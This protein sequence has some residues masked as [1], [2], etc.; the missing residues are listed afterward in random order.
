MSKVSSLENISLAISIVNWR[1]GS[2]VCNCLESLNA[3]IDETIHVIVVDNGSGDGSEKTIA[4]KIE[5]EGW[6]WVTQIALTENRGFAAGNNAAIR[7]A[8]ANFP[9]LESLMLLNPDTIMLPGAIATMSD[10]L[11]S[12]SDVG[13]VG[14]RSEHLDGT[15]QDCSFKFYNPIS[16]FGSNLRFALLNKLLSR[17]LNNGEI[18]EKSIEVDWVSGAFMLIRKEVIDD[19][20]LM[21]EA[22]FLYFEEVDF[23]LR[24]KREGWRCWH[25]PDARIVHLVGQSSGVTSDR[26]GNAR[27]PVYWYESRSR[28]FL[29]NYGR[30]YALFCDLLAIIGCGLWQ[31]R[32]FISGKAN[33]NPV[34]Y[35]PDLVRFGTFGVL[36]S[37]SKP[38]VIS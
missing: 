35:L 22:Y 30:S 10:F 32:C 6:A 18:P 12:N 9:K 34:R 4:E 1:T 5:L 26:Q 8:E 11:G 20:G 3:E 2:L 37:K 15:P 25:L 7:F 36:M 16:E 17:F 27:R 21:D 33:P 28:Y 19:I 29:V 24:A 14:G 38:R 23:I 13:I 31:L